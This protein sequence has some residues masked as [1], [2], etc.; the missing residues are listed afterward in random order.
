M[1]DQFYSPT[2]RERC[3]FILA[4]GTAVEC[5]NLCE[6]EGGFDFKADDLVKYEDA[7]ASW[8]THPGMPSNL[9]NG[10]RQSFLAWPDMQH[11]VIGADGTR[12]FAVQMNRVVQ[13]S[14]PT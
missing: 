2:G 14:G 11:M 5:E 10:D 3:G 8:H 6:S 9:S 1:I 13:I 7:K 12:V 4:D